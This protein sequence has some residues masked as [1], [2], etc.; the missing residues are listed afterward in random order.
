MDNNSELATTLILK[1]IDD[2]E[3]DGCSLT[4]EGIKYMIKVYSDYE[5]ERCIVFY[6]NGRLDALKFLSSP[7]YD[8]SIRLKKEIENNE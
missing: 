2:C 5:R 3:R 7:N 1:F 4:V 8:Y 6:N